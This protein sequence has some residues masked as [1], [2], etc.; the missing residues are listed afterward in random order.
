MEKISHVSWIRRAWGIVCF[1]WLLVFM[2]FEVYSAA[3][4]ALDRNPAFPSW[5]PILG[6][7]LFVLPSMLFAS[8]FL[9]RG[10]HPRLGFYLVVGNLGL[11]ASFMI[12]SYLSPVELQDGSPPT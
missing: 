4:T 6:W 7:F 1:T 5:E 2:L 8:F 10:R 12:L 9:L 11:Y 3:A